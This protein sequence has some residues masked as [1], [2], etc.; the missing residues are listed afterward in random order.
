MT[1]IDFYILGDANQAGRYLTACR[2]AEKAFGLGHRVHVH[3][4][5]PEEATR[6]DDLLWTFRDG[7]FV[8]HELVREDGADSPVTVS[9]RW[10]PTGE[11]EVLINLAPDVPPFFSRFHRV[12]E[13]IDRDE[14]Q[15]R[16][17]RERFRFYRD[18]GYDLNTHELER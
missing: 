7:S 8:P 4:A 13:I 10:E 9:D 1:R 5:S 15:R 6:L 2:L 14:E 16:H 12:A 17:G 11:C 18:R 3:T